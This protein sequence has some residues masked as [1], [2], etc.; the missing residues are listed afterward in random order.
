VLQ[1]VNNKAHDAVCG[2][3]PMCMHVGRHQQGFDPPSCRKT[4]T[5]CYTN[6][7]VCGKTLTHGTRWWS[8]EQWSSF[9]LIL[10]S[11]PS[12]ILLVCVCFWILCHNLYACPTFLWSSFMMLH[13]VCVCARIALPCFQPLSIFVC[14]LPWDI[15]LYVCGCVL[16]DP[17]FGL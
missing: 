7:R 10:I 6:T 8:F 1:C 15:F 9:E 4:P 3:T 12:L 11:V 16:L 5:W 2:K 14:V 13:N 17:I